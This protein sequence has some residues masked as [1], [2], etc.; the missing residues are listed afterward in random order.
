VAASTVASV[1][2]HGGEN[3][4]M[5]GVELRSVRRRFAAG[6]G[7][8]ALPHQVLSLVPASYELSPGM[9]GHQVSKPEFSNHSL[10]FNMGL[11]L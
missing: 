1:L 10:V 9:T 2:W 6:A 5:R 8:A 3:A 4:C 7:L 11:G